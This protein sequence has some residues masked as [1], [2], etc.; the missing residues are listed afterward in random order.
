MTFPHYNTRPLATTE[1]PAA[2]GL[3][4]AVGVHGVYLYNVLAAHPDLGPE[5]EILALHGREQLLGLAYFGPRGNLL[6]VHREPLDP[7][8]L[9][10]AMLDALW[11]WR[12]VLAAAPVVAQLVRVGGLRPLV[13]REQIY[14]SIT[15]DRL[16]DGVATAE[17]RRGK[18]KDLNALMEAALHLNETDLNV[19]RWRVDRDWLKGNTK[20]RIRQ[21]TTFVMGPVGK[22]VAKLDLGS[23]GPA[24]V[25]IEGVYTW[26]A[27][28]G[29]GFAASLIAAVA[30]LYLVD[31]PLV[32]LH[33]AASNTAARRSY[34]KCG[35]QQVASC[36]LML[37]D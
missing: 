10:R 8:A 32:C 29:R 20:T 21:G 30:G 23:V 27:M 17:V 34:E 26:P 9:A 13:D 7:E 11:P 12:I 1:V 31:R 33:V 14:Y 15:G 3:A 2:L 18:K 28:R 35:M 6:V 4:N 5:A 19:D 36:Q 25:V 24:G 16:G 22:P 37:R